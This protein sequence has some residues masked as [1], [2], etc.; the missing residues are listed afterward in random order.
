MRLSLLVC[1]VA[2]LAV[3]GNAQLLSSLLN[4]LQDYLKVPSLQTSVNLLASTSAVKCDNGFFPFGN[5]YCL[6]VFRLPPK[7][8]SAA[9]KACQDIGAKLFSPDYIRPLLAD[10]SKLTGA[11]SLRGASF[12]IGGISGG[13]SLVKSIT[14]TL[15]PGLQA[16]RDFVLQLAKSAG[17]NAN[18]FATRWCG[19]MTSSAMAVDNGKCLKVSFLGALP[20]VQA[21]DCNQASG[22]VCQ[23]VEAEDLSVEET[24]ETAWFSLT[25]GNDNSDFESFSTFRFDAKRK[26]LNVPTCTQPLACYCRK[27]GDNTKI[28]DAR[29]GINPFSVN[30]LPG[31]KCNIVGTDCLLK[32]QR[33][34]L[35]SCFD[36][37]MKVV[38]PISKVTSCQSPQVSENCQKQN[39][40]C[41]DRP[42]GPVCV[43]KPST[44]VSFQQGTCTTT[45]GSIDYRK[46]SATGDPHYTT[47]DGLSY[48]FQGSCCYV[49]ISVC[50]PADGL[51]DFKVVV[52][53][54]HRGTNMAVTFTRYVIVFINNRQ[55][56]FGTNLFKVD[57][58]STPPSY[59]TNGVTV[60]SQQTRQGDRLT[61]KLVTDNCIIVEWDGLQN[62]HVSMSKA[63]GGRVC[64]LCGNMNGQSTDE[65][66]PKGSKTTI[67]SRLLF[68]DSW[69]FEH[70][71]YATNCS[72]PTKTEPTCTTAWRD[73]FKANQY[74][75]LLNPANNDSPFVKVLLPA[76]DQE[77]KSY[78]TMRYENCLLDHCI[79]NGADPEFVRDKI[80][81]SILTDV[82]NTI[83]KNLK[84][85]PASS[86]RTI[87]ACPLNCDLDPNTESTDKKLECEDSCLNRNAEA[88]CA[89]PAPRVGCVC[90]DGFIRDGIQGKCVPENTCEVQC[91]QVVTDPDDEESDVIPT[92]PNGGSVLVE[93]CKRSVTCVNGTATFQALPACSADASCVNSKCECNVGF[94]GDGYTC[95]RET[96]ECNAGFIGIGRKC[97]KVIPNNL[98]WADAARACCGMNA[99]LARVDSSEENDNLRLFVAGLGLKAGTSIW[100]AGNT[101]TVAPG[102]RLGELPTSYDKSRYIVLPEENTRLGCYYSELTGEQKVTEDCKTL[103]PTIC[104]Y[105]NPDKEGD[106]DV[107]PALA[108]IEYFRVLKTSNRNE[109]LAECKRQGGKLPEPRTVGEQNALKLFQEQRNLPFIHIGLQYKLGSDKD[110][111]WLSGGVVPFGKPG[112]FNAWGLKYPT[113]T[114]P[115]NMNSGQR[116]VV[117]DMANNKWRTRSETESFG[118]VCQREVK[119]DAKA[120]RFLKIGTAKVAFATAK[121]QCRAQGRGLVVARTQPEL[122]ELNQFASTLNEI[123]LD[124]EDPQGTF[125]WVWKD[126]SPLSLTNLWFSG[127]PNNK[128]QEKCGRLAATSQGYRFRSSPCA[129]AVGFVVCGPRARDLSYVW[130]PYIRTT[131]LVKKTV[132][133]L[134]QEQL[135]LASGTRFS[136]ESPLAMD[137][138]VRDAASGQYVN[139]ENRNPLVQCT[140]NNILCVNNAKID[141]STF[142]VRF[143]C[144]NDQNLCQSL[145]NPCSGGQ[146]CVPEPG[147]CFTCQCPQGFSLDHTGNCN[148]PCGFCELRGDPHYTATDGQHFDFQGRCEYLLNG[149]CPAAASTL[150]PGILRYD[151]KVQ[152]TPCGDGSVTCMK[153]ATVNFYNVPVSASEKRDF[154][155]IRDRTTPTFMVNNVKYT[156]LVEVKNADSGEL[157][158]RAKMVKGLFTLEAKGGF[159]LETQA[160]IVKVVPPASLRDEMCGLCGQCTNLYRFGN[161]TRVKLPVVGTKIAAPAAAAF[162]NTWLTNSPISDA[163]RTDPGTPPSACSS[164]RRVQAEKLCEPLRNQTSDFSP[165]FATV[166]PEH[167][168]EDCVFDSC[169]DNPRDICEMMK[170]YADKCTTQGIALSWRNPGRCPLI[171]DAAMNQEYSDNVNCQP[172]CGDLVARS[173]ND[174]SASDGCRCKQGFFVNSGQC[175]EVEKC[176]CSY[177]SGSTMV[178]L[179]PGDVVYNRDCTKKVTCVTGLEF[180][181]EDFQKDPNAICTNDE[182]PNLECALGFIMKADGVTCE[183]DPFECSVDRGFEDLSGRC[184]EIPTEP[185]IWRRA[186]ERCNI[187]N[188]TLMVVDVFQKLRELKKIMDRD[189]LR[190]AFI[191]GQVKLTKTGQL[192]H[193]LSSEQREL[194]KYRNFG[195]SD[196]ILNRLLPPFEVNPA[197]LPEEGA[198]Y[199]IAA[200]NQGDVLTLV[201]VPTSAKLNFVCEERTD[202]PPA[203]E[204]TPYCSKDSPAS[205]DDEVERVSTL[206]QNPE[207]RMCPNPAAMSCR[208]LASSKGSRQAPD[209]CRYNNG[210]LYS[211]QGADCADMEVSGTCPPDLDE[212]AERLHDCTKEQVCENT[213]GAYLCRCTEDKPLMINNECK[214]VDQCEMGGS[215]ST[216]Y[217]YDLR[218]K[219][220]SAAESGNLDYDC[221]MFVANVCKPDTILTRFSV[222]VDNKKVEYYAR[223]S[224]KITVTRPTLEGDKTS[225]FEF[226][227]ELLAA[228][229]FKM[230]D[231]TRQSSSFQDPATRVYVT[232]MGI[233]GSFM[234]AEEDSQ[235]KFLIA[236][237]ADGSL[238]R[239][240][241]AVSSDYRS[242]LCGLCS[243]PAAKRFSLQEPFNSQVSAGNRLC[244]PIATTPQPTTTPIPTTT[245]AP[246]V[247]TQ[248]TTTK[249]PPLTTTQPTTLPPTTLPPVDPCLEKINF[250]EFLQSLCSGV[251]VSQ[252]V[253]KTCQQGVSNC[254]YMET[255]TFL[256][257]QDVRVSK[258]QNLVHSSCAAECGSDQMF[259]LWPVNAQQPTC[260]NREFDPLTEDGTHD[261]VFK[262]MCDR[263]R[264]YFYENGKCIPKTECG[265]V[266]PTGDYRPR[267][268]T[269]SDP[270][271][272]N[273][274]ACTNG[275]V[276]TNSRSC[277]DNAECL[278]KE[279]R[280][281]CECPGADKGRGVPNMSNGCQGVVN[282]NETCYLMGTKDEV[283]YC[284]EGF[285]PT[286]NGCEDI[287]EC[288]LGAV[289]DGRRQRCKN[290]VG[291]YECVCQDGFDANMDG[292]CVDINECQK[293]T[294]ECIK[295]AG[296]GARCLNFIGGF[297]CQCCAGYDLAAGGKCQRNTE[298]VPV[299]PANPPCC[300]CP[301]NVP[302]CIIPEDGPAYGCYKDDKGQNKAYAAFRFLYEEQCLQNK[303]VDPNSWT[304]GDCPNAPTT[305]KLPQTGGPGGSGGSGATNPPPPENP[306]NPAAVCTDILIPPNLKT[307]AVCGPTGPRES[308]FSSY[309]KL[310][311][312]VCKR[313]GGPN[314][315]PP[316]TPAAKPGPCSNP[317]PPTT[318]PGVTPA[319]LNFGPWTQWTPCRLEDERDVAKGCGRG[320]QFRSREIADA[321]PARQALPS[322]LQQDQPCYVQCPT[323]TTSAAGFTTPTPIIIDPGCPNVEE[324][325]NVDKVCGQVGSDDPRTFSSDCALNAT[326]CNR[327][328]PPAKLYHG[329]CTKDD[330]EPKK[331]CEDV[332]VKYPQTI[333]LSGRPEC[334]ADITIGNCS[335]RL[336]KGS[337][338]DSCCEPDG[339][340][341]INVLFVCTGREFVDVMMSI[342]TSCKCTN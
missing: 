234:L 62:V 82:E 286:C 113:T 124:L 228:G 253:E 220:F 53:N 171:C 274:Y 262:C 321:K 123:W 182:P 168:Y 138:E 214:E 268:D 334:K 315:M 331:Y 317:E 163:C 200:M 264:G 323:V 94:K 239:L 48:D 64:G 115:D 98:P 236:P 326:A 164:A 179:K 231:A 254:Q 198:V 248:R 118:L 49:L 88:A 61:Y 121:E 174:V 285:A 190:S 18:D 136:C 183:R 279:G 244:T 99:Q 193:I 39:K 29:K 305:P 222:V 325:R 52:C 84:I 60:T 66:I 295:R 125:T 152:N 166:N 57:G 148:K 33:T 197:L 50:D 189:G 215:A 251:V 283:C 178:S 290:T 100:V 273:D 249:A 155:I 34:L 25:S 195:V 258:L 217:S 6:K 11:I 153:V 271:C 58:V 54:I 71:E 36:F 313:V 19:K 221:Q 3:T 9:A 303:N 307:G 93:P 169:Q 4:K 280:P 293:M 139:A 119:E 219:P 63:Y 142:R 238:E 111:E 135:K 291:S 320:S 192:R 270:Q 173:C 314:K 296:E 338:T 120:E 97:Y 194:I 161:G 24:E 141:C 70:P 74:C 269:W 133:I 28:I 26:G 108:K 196:F 216:A 41:Q 233:D 237:R 337:S 308:T 212:C 151:V 157:L 127:E 38:C 232:A 177:Q 230:N 122:L 80:T 137:C 46:C 170:D 81:C 188:A 187:L 40:N 130:S 167:A 329:D 299:L 203:Y 83:L 14:G 114:E 42:T 292:I 56:H 96:K 145:G 339:V 150:A 277:D 87:A 333:K 210:L 206:M 109:G 180:E 10:L 79:D 91:F 256:Q 235:F 242:K 165:C 134:L 5:K 95:T 78:L 312:D 276:V 316:A 260:T 116:A 336:C 112:I 284:N 224:L 227:Q 324:C 143:F 85:S 104:E 76:T 7:S 213:N 211:C 272:K 250:C 252:C 186:V 318:T 45:A 107:G 327:G 246:I 15:S 17:Q 35:Q 86:W 342:P 223:Q 37:E 263:D 16:E 20:E 335:E 92:I 340:V 240:S 156:D 65:F 140:V 245:T 90:K 199:A 311:I 162:A 257:C 131:A 207:C 147:G 297:S 22:Y 172:Q 51:A 146:Q 185:R 294:D 181:E 301:T 319:S 175:V 298:R 281:V 126:G 261:F 282:G 267:G 278:T 8:W 341:E 27:K 247:T 310:L 243:L 289:C 128:G 300:S 44:G 129:S 266:M 69:L 322:E 176:G 328:L 23:K 201:A 55:F 77:S 75:G 229:N 184:V 59:S 132:Q 241:V 218:L 304:Y 30:L 205:N 149:I 302:Q 191:S 72:L 105:A 102:K 110:F 202:D 43:D 103:R 209:Q 21:A 67:T 306:C 255:T 226:S 1:L 204:P 13:E 160:T 275:E 287:N 265:C 208:K 309:C 32:C 144:P 89:N 12:Y 101:N 332:L 106:D 68:G 31:F 225:T 158:L 2:S 259:V 288:A 154:V 73:K 330:A 159:W 47:F 117:S